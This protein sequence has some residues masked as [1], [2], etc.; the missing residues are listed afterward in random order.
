[1]AMFPQPVASSSQNV[2]ALMV[3]V[4]T[5]TRSRSHNRPHQNVVLQINGQRSICIV[6]QSTRARL[7]HVVSDTIFSAQVWLAI[8]S[9]RTCID[10]TY[11]RQLTAPSISSAAALVF[12]YNLPAMRQYRTS[13]W[14]II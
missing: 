8:F 6:S 12:E 2:A 11:W 13:S 14:G 10:V 3:S 7:L 9:T 1:M 5:F 4:A